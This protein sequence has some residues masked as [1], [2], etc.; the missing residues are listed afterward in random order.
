MCTHLAGQYPHVLKDLTAY[1]TMRE[2]LEQGNNDVGEES[3][4]IARNS[5]EQIFTS[6]CSQLI[7]RTDRLGIARKKPSSPSGRHSRDEAH[8][9]HVACQSSR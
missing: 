4:K 8:E 1:S 7:A 6:C 2:R 5:F 3:T 9:G